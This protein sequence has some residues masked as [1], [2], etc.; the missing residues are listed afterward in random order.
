MHVVGKLQGHPRLHILVYR[1]YQLFA[2][3]KIKD[4]F[5]CMRLD[6]ELDCFCALDCLC[7]SFIVSLNG[8][9]LLRVRQFVNS[10]GGSERN[11]G[12]EKISKQLFSLW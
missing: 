4:A 1:G 2:P 3:V 5:V 12:V 7:Y 6:L 11:L 9:R 10:A 8:L